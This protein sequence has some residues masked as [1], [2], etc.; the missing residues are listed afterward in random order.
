MSW[1][2]W[3][4]MLMAQNACGTWTSRARNSA[5]IKYHAV[6]SFFNN[7]VYFANLFVGVDKIATADSNWL[8]AFTLFFY[9]L[10]TMLGSI[11]SHWV[12]MHHVET[13][14]HHTKQIV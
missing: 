14:F 13:K 10:F 6:A 12:L 5:S 11:A 2:W 9:A 7:G 1:F 8:I 4:L 3:A